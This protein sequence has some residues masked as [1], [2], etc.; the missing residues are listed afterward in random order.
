MDNVLDMGVDGRKCDGTDPYLFKWG[1]YVWSHKGIISQREYADLYYRDFFYY[2][3]TKNPS[4]LIMARPVDSWE[5][6]YWNF[7][8]HDVMFSGWVG[9]Q[10][11]T[12]EGMQ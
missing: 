12:W 2:S 11:P 7:A 9:D 5:V 6:V 10:L 8:P 4:S 3:R 1:G